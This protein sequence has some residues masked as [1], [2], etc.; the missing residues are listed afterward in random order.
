MV[1]SQV[2]YISMENTGAKGDTKLCIRNHVVDTK[3]MYVFLGS[4]V[5][6]A[7]GKEIL[8]AI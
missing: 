2:E 6:E 8:H 5:V 1:R 7:K 4:C 3:A